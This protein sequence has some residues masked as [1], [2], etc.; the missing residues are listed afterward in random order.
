MSPCISDSNSPYKI[1]Y[2]ILVLTLCSL[3]AYFIT[4]YA[5]K[6]HI[7]TLLN[8]EIPG[9]YAIL[10]ELSSISTAFI[11]YLIGAF[12]FTTIKLMLV[13]IF[14]EQISKTNLWL[15]IG[16]GLTPMLIEDYFYWFNLIYYA[17]ANTIRTIEDFL[18]LKYSFNLSISDF[19][20]LNIFCWC[21]LYLTMI[22]FLY[23]KSYPLYKVLLSTLL[24][25]IFVILTYYW[26]S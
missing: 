13:D 11:P 23:I 3:C 24:P 12:L 20:T 17:D 16:I 15:M 22:L 10:F 6:L 4:D 2:V 26:L 9:S 19:K 7:H 18:N 25:S 5:N 14:D 8:G 1:G 21:L